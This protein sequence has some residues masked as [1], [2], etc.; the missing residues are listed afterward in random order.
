MHFFLATLPFGGVGKLP[1]LLFNHFD[2][3]LVRTA[4]AALLLAT[5][6]TS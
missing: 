4:V 2:L 1:E 6:V 5:S 3:L